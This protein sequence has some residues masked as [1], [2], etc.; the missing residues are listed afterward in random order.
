MVSGL[1][2]PKLSEEMTPPGM[3]ILGD[4]AFMKNNRATNGK[5]MRDDSQMK[6]GYF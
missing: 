1:Y 2:F 5:I 6:Q 4:S 3:A